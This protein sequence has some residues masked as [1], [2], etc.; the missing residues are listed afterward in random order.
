MRSH[1]KALV[2]GAVLV[3]LAGL[4]P[5]GHAQTG[6]GPGPAAKP[7]TK[8]LGGLAELASPSQAAEGPGVSISYPSLVVGGAVVIDAT[9]QNDARDLLTDLQRLGLTGAAVS[10]RVVS[11]KLPLGSIGALGRLTSAHSIRPAAATTLT[12]SVNGQGDP[13]M[14][15][16]T[17]RAAVPV[18]GAGNIVGTLSDSYDCLGGAPAGVAS[19]DL[20]AGVNVLDDTA[21]PATD[22]GRGMMELI[23]D[24]APG[25]GQAFHTAFTGQAGFAQG[26]LDLAAAGADIINDDVGYFAEPMFQDGII[27]QAVDQVVGMGIP[28]Y[29]SAGNANAD[30]YEQAFR[31]GPNECTE[32]GVAR[33]G[34]DFDP[35]P[36]VD[37]RQRITFPSGQTVLSL[38][39]DQPFFSVSGPPGSASDIDVCFYTTGGVF[40]GGAFSPNAGGDPVEVVGISNPGPPVS[41]DI[42]IPRYSGPSPGRLKYVMFRASASIDQFATNSST[43]VGHNNAA[44]ASATGA[45]FALQTPRFG[46]NPP[47]L[48]PFSSRGGTPILFNTAGAPIAPVVRQTPDVTGP[49]GANTTFFGTDSAADPDALP[50]FF[51]T[52]AAAPHVAALAALLRQLNPGWTPAQLNSFLETTAIDMGPPG[53]D[54]DSGHGLVQVGPALLAAACVEPVPPPGAILGGPGNDVLNGTAGNDVIFGFGGADAIDGRGGNDVIYGGPGADRLLGGTGD[55]T[56]CGGADADELAGTD[57]AD[58]LNGGAG[59]DK[60]SGGPGNDALADFSGNDQLSANEGND[61]LTTLDGAGGDALVG[62]PHATADICASDP[63]DAPLQCNP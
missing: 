15:T 62:G 32:S 14:N 50:N 16:D 42:A 7:A 43:S 25:A 20:P 56:L 30:S 4:A 29:S 2:L 22:E 57:G 46:V 28:Y 1:A 35:G 24:V 49:D 3:V 12:G 54:R 44:G 40:I 17:F 63:G 61:S 37:T 36:G 6:A 38:Q 53:Y 5:A 31:P 19:N 18:T 33:P 51:G 10:G 27:A 8:L 58:R 47:L 59:N 41:L 39:W 13:A 60:L 26:I 23:H 34:H 48:E 55:D 21:C 9:A 11:G 52:S 45:A